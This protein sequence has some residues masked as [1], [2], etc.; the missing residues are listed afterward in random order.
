MLHKVVMMLAAAAVGVGFAG[1]AEA[2][3]TFKIGTLAPPS[4]PW[5]TGFKKWA[6]EVAE[7]TGG[8]LVLD[9]QWN[10]SAG[11]DVLMVQKVRAGQLDGAA[12]TAL[13]LAQTGVKDILLFQLPG[14]FQNWAKL[15]AARDATKDE[16]AKQFEQKGFA[17]VGWGD[18][19]ALK[20]MSVGF[21]VH[22]PSDFQGKN[23]CFFTGDS[24]SPKLFDAIGG[25]TPKQL[26]ITEVLPGL[27][28]GAINVITAPPLGAEQFQWAS[29]VTDVNSESVAYAIGAIVVSSSRLQSLPPKLRDSLLARGKETSEELTKVIR[30]KDAQAWERMK[31]TKTIY[32]P[33]AQEHNEWRDV[34]IK[35]A[36]SLKGPVFSG[37]M[38]KKVVTLAANPEVQ[39]GD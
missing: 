22:H 26:G 33:T 9:F 35:V 12:V 17:I 29:H 7:D 27:T 21:Q 31:K 11:D 6:K 16:F 20:T 38:F 24:I 5:A 37:D 10:G 3:T 28:A 14:L 15:D 23:P 32:T 30:N 19:G 8:E 36:K 4:S 25:I 1:S 18:V 2:A 39:I 13:G 34:F